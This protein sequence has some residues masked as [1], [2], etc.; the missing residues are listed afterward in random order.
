MTV[1]STHSK[2]SAS[3][4]PDGDSLVTVLVEGFQVVAMDTHEAVKIGNLEKKESHPVVK[5][6]FGTDFPEAVS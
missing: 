2:L 3:Q 1:W 6:Q 5:P 4:N